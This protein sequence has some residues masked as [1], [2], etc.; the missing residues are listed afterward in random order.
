MNSPAPPP[1]L[2]EKI[3]QLLLIGFRGLEITD[4]DPIARDLAER[5][6]GGVVLF[7]QDMTDPSL[8]ARN[9]RSARQVA[10]LVK[11]LQARARTPPFVAID[12]E[13]GCV[14]RLKPIYGFAPSLSH[15]ELGALN[16]SEQTYA[17]AQT[18]AKTL[19]D[20]GINFN[21]A[22]VLDLDANPDNPIIKGK[23]RSFSSDP[24]IV[25][26]HAIEFVRAHHR[27]GILTC[28]KHFPGHGSSR[29]DTHLGLVDVTRYW[30][31]QELLPYRRLIEAGLCDTVMTAHIFNA[32]L[33]PQRPATLSP[34]VVGG[35]LRGRLGF[36][37]VALSDDLEM[38][39]IS[40]HYS[41]GPALQYAIEAG[42]DVLCL[43]NNMNFDLNIGQKAADL[44]FRLVET[45]KIS[46][47]RIDESCRRIER[48]KRKFKLL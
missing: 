38:K 2:R 34:S 17:H 8:P 35:I 12:Q 48:L 5:N 10:A 3:G 44:I 4:A 27:H 43:G 7:D 15:E 28:A 26:R 18:I 46:E 23:K 9:I 42:L 14:N 30:S 21:L 41:L 25:A 13:G 36:D 16:D 22:P 6:L 24:Q 32:N 47:A 45:G 29:G 1:S 19:A 40:S 11:S 33:D 20:L 31:E 39:A 37:G